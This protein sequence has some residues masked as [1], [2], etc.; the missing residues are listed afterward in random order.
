MKRINL[1]GLRFG[2]LLILNEYDIYNGSKRY[3]CICDCGKSSIVFH[4]NLKK[5]NT[6]SCGCIEKEKWKKII[7]KHG[8]YGSPEY[9]A[10][11]NMLQRCY[12]KKNISYYNYG[13]R[14]IT[15]CDRWKTS[16]L[17]FLKDMGRKPDLE[18]TLDRI[19]NNK[20]YFPENCQWATRSQQNKNRREFTRNKN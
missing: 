11:R 16:Y 18:L 13:E 7:T 19:N 9:I 3:K 17:M 15:V 12:Y 1:S 20:G 5:G 6:K 4:S 8:D 14:G 2:R 10:W